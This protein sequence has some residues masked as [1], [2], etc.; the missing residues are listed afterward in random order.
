MTIP[1]LITLMRLFLVPVIIWLI[2]DGEYLAAFW[3]FVVAGVSDAV[4]GFIAK[5]FDVVSELGS[6]LDPIAD[7]ALLVS[8]YITLATVG[9]L[10]FWLVVAVVS[11]DVLIIG[12]VL[13]SWM[14]ERPVAMQPLYISKTNTVA[15]I[16][17]ASVVLGALG[18]GLELGILRSVL[19][20]ATAVLTV[21]S[22]IAYLVE[23]LRHM[24]EDD[25]SRKGENTP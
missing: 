4:D 21:L 3:V 13:L 5:R 18:F 20:V 1:N 17:L 19:V 24:A 10:P 22:A 11:R 25:A 2:G 15:Q 23:W 8:I 9:Q 7:K 12:A 14:M 16:M 6:Y